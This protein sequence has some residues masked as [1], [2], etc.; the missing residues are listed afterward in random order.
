[1]QGNENTENTETQETTAQETTEHVENKTEN[2]EEIEIVESVATEETTTT[3]EIPTAEELIAQLQREVTDAKDKHLRLYAEFENFR[4]RTAKEKLDLTQNAGEKVIV[5]M[6]T[7]LDDFERAQKSLQK[8]QERENPTLEDTQKS[9][10]SIN[11][12]VQLI[13]NKLSRIL[14]QQG[15]KAIPNTIGTEFNIDLHE[16]ITQIPAPTE[17]MKGKVVDE[18][19]KGYQLN[20]KV[21]RFAK[22]VIGG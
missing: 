5:A 7:V 15:L 19:E 13:Y 10:Q 18:V 22:V 2:I 14:E 4:R 16:S 17:D 1:M 6:L 8:A 11:D 9:L 20:E 12:G 3:K 21:I